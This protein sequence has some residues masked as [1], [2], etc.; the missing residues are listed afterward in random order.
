MSG[1]EPQGLC[2]G[3]LLSHGVPAD[4]DA[5]V[6]LFRL[7]VR[8]VSRRG[9]IVRPRVV[10]AVRDYGPAHVPV[11]D[12]ALRGGAREVYLVEHGMAAALGMDIAVAEP[13]LEAVLT[14]SEDWFDFSV[15]SLGGTLV[16]ASAGIGVETLLEDARNHL[17]LRASFFRSAAR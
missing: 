17:R 13:R 11:K 3:S 5:C 2:A 15:I 14:L 7:G 6:E 8:Q 1:R 9:R 16:S 10:V 4:Q 12:M